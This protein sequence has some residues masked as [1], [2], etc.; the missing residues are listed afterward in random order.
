MGHSDSIIELTTNL[1]DLSPQAYETVMERLFAAGALDVTM[2][3]VMM[4]RMR[5]GVTLSVLVPPEK[6]HAAAS[7]VLHETTALGLRMQPM[8]RRTLARRFASVSLADGEVR[9]KLAA[10]DRDHTK[11]A[12][13]YLDC[14]RI[15]EQTGRPVKDVME[16]A[17]VAYHLQRRT[18][19]KPAGP[20]RR[21]RKR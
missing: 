15:A 13:E 16:E 20:V 14:K 11:A 8:Q 12:P 10:L 9:M 7:V 19:Q 3:S 21:T 6:A 18:K 1:D 2:T 17:T 5:P 4:K